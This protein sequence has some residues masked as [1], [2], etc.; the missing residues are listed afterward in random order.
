MK[1]GHSIMIRDGLNDLRHGKCRNL[2]KPLMFSNSTLLEIW[3]F[4]K[5][6]SNE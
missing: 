6:S 5:E 4:Y 2:L 1:N 3:P